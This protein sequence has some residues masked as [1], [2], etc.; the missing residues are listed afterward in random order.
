MIEIEDLIVEFRGFKLEI[1]NLKIDTGSYQ[2]IMGPSGV[3]KTVL[4]YALTGFIRPASGRIYLN[5]IDVTGYPPEERGF[6][7]VPE[8][9]GLFPHMNAYDNISYGLK[10]RGYEDEYIKNKVYK[11]ADILEIENILDRKPDTLSAG[12]KQRVAIAR[13]LA[14][15]PNII[16]LDEPLK[17]LD[18]RIRVRAINLLK[19]M[20]REIGFTAL[21]VTHDIIEAVYLATSIVYIEDGVLRGVYKPSEFIKSKFGAQYMEYLKLFNI[22]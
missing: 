17:G 21:H 14:I 2:I 11:L 6:T 20:W 19:K 13:A 22:E 12:E 16:L 15:D 8:D 1:K 18:P 10:K 4:L 9:Y 7:I 5:G 3:G